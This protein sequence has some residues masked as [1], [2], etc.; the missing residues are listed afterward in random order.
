MPKQLIKGNEAVVKGAILAGC[1]YFF[2]YPITPAS[3]IAEAAAYYLP[4][5]GGTFLQAESEIAS[6]QMAYGAASGGARVMTASSSPGISLKQEGISYAA[7]SELPLVVGDIVRGGPGLGNIAPEQG[8]YNQIVKGGGH[9]NYK[10]IVLAPNCAQEMCDLTMLAFEL[11]DKYRNPVAILADGF[12]GQM[13]EPV[14]FPEAITELPDKPWALKADEDDQYRLITSINLEPEDLEKH[15]QK[16]QAK[17]AEIEATEIR[18]EEYQTEDAEIVVIGY[19]IV[20][21][22]LQTVVDIMR[23][24]GRKIG[25]LRPIT[26]WPFPSKRIAELSKQAAMFMVVE[27]SNGQMVDD[28][29]LAVNGSKPVHFYNRMGGVVP[30]PEEI[31]EQVVKLIGN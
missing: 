9:G 14:E 28:V 23:H 4:L 30:A 6:I 1:R 18:Y 10:L 31:Y 19:G 29:R 20:S 13:M 21:R 15:N 24:E 5:V 26:L 17:Y 25:M 8:D 22:L 16:L 2:G 3:E 11:A 7:G 27:L 12:I